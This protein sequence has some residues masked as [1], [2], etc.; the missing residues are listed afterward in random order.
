MD[1]ITAKEVRS[2]QPKSTPS[3]SDLIIYF[4]T[5]TGI[6]KITHA[7]FRAYLQSYFA[8]LENGIVPESQLPSYVDELVEGYYS[9]GTF[10]E[11]AGHITPIT[12]AIDKVYLDLNNSPDTYR[13]GGTEYALIGGGLELGENS[14]DAYRGD[15]GK[16]AYDYSQG[17]EVTAIGDLD[18]FYQGW[19]Y[20]TSATGIAFETSYYLYSVQ[21]E[22]D[23]DTTP[24]VATQKAIT[25]NG[26]YTRT[27]TSGTWSSW[28][29][30]DKSGQ[31]TLISLGA[32]A[33]ADLTTLEG[34]VDNV[35]DDILDIQADILTNEAAI[36]AIEPIVLTA[37]TTD[38]T[39]VEMLDPSGSS[40][41]TMVEPYII[42]FEAV[43]TN[44]ATAVY[45][46]CYMVRHNSSSTINYAY[47]SGN[48]VTSGLSTS[49][50]EGIWYD[51]ATQKFYAKGV[52]ATT[53]N[54]RLV[55]SQ[56]I[57][58]DIS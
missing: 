5:S 56:I 13:W 8:K 26:L 35:E 47:K 28:D 18:T 38:D 21:C 29:K 46:N 32:A 37:T 9:G 42:N 15:R 43:A 11:E 19:G 50:T 52:L 44:G 23:D 3:D 55:I 10:Y 12:P 6:Y 49:E 14:T 39:S 22:A 2:A 51:A 4:G 24:T 54:W 25:S 17:T 30:T 31:I 58:Q 1:R 34:R 27:Y 7:Q 33:D 36:E 48:G 53:I 41:T 20:V 40:L 45:V 16:I 57:E